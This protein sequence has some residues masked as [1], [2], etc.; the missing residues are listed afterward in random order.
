VFELPLRT[1]GPVTST[2]TIAP[3]R[4]TM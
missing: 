1:L 3:P 4:T 2:L